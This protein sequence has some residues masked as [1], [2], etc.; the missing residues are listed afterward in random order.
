MEPILQVKQLNIYAGQGTARNKLV[1]QLDLTIHRGETVALVGESGSGKSLTANAIL[2]L[3]PKSLYVG[4]GQ[5]RFQGEDILLWSDKKKRKLRGKQ[6]GS[7]FQDYQNSFTPFLKVGNQLVE[8][9]RTH[10]QLSFNEAKA[11]AMKWL[12]DV[13][14]PAERVFDSYPFQLSGGQRQRAAI[15][16]AMMLQP[17]LLIADEVTTALDVLTGERVL[18]LLADLQR[19]TGCVV[20]M[21]S[22]D[23]RHVL[24]RADTIAVMKDGRIMEKESAEYIRLQA[25]HPYTQM[26]LKARPLLSE[27]HT[28]LAAEANEDSEQA[29]DIIGVSG[30]RL[31]AVQ[32]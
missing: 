29:P 32:I 12:Q 15:A 5:I 7:V 6:M 27:I 26:L 25:N 28:E 19:Q 3:L 24:K 22:H 10:Q 13:G 30:N 20:L 9:I 31:E 1:H 14:L 18:D 2:G 16:A 8:T 11:I 21:I 4:E 23:L 17:A